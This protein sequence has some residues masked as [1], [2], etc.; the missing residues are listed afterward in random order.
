VG[1]SGYGTGPQGER[2][3]D[4]SVPCRVWPYAEELKI[5]GHPALPP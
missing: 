3:F 4:T 1:R 5:R 2:Y